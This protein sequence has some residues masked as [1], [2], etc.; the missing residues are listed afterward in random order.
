VLRRAMRHGHSTMQADCDGTTM[1]DLRVMH[2]RAKTK[3]RRAPRIA[4]GC[5]TVT[6][7]LFGSVRMACWPAFRIAG[8]H[9]RHLGPPCVG[10]LRCAQD[11]SRGLAPQCDMLSRDYDLLR[12]AA[13][14]G[15]HC[16]GCSRCGRLGVVRQGHGAFAA[17]PPS[18]GRRC[19]GFGGSV[20][21]R[22][23][24]PAELS[25]HVSVSSMT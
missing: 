2:E 17:A 8:S 13:V 3:P 5:P 14:R 11:T 18:S 12:R 15:L 23:L 4:R 20:G 21:F 22:R 16:D 9:W 1:P 7:R 24:T 25:E 6:E 10:A 19:G